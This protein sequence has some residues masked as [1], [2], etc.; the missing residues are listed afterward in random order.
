MLFSLNFNVNDLKDKY[1][2]EVIKTLGTETMA[3][4]ETY[5]SLLTSHE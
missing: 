2:S 1:T 5:M 4:H 3:L